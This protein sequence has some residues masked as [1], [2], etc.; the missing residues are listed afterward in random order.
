MYQRIRDNPAHRPKY[1]HRVDSISMATPD[2]PTSLMKITVRD[3]P[4]FNS[5]FYSHVIS[6][7]PFSCLRCVDLTGSNLDYKQKAA[8]R[9]LNYGAGIKVGIKFKT[10]WWQDR[11]LFPPQ[12][13]GVS[14]TD[15]QSRVV[16]YPSY[17]LKD[18]PTDPGVLIAAYNWFV[19]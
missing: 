10:R 4:E 13:G 3:Y 18:H 11:E 17:G 16:V 6:T 14:S 5:K 2:K 1:N 9:C 19:S 7:L 12:V 15:R 8:L